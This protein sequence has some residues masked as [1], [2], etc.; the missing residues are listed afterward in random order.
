MGA[1]LHDALDFRRVVEPGAAA[2]AASR[3]ISPADRTALLAALE[4]CSSAS[5]DR[6]RRGADSRLHLM[7]AGLAGSDLLL[8]AVV[9]VR[10]RGG[11][12]LAAFRVLRRNSAHSD[13]Q[14]SRTA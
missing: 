6:A 4:A 7:V 14:Q 1:R 8:S 9:D 3:E 13:P 11:G 12:L 5:D 2:L 10:L